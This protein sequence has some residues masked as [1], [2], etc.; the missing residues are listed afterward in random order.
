[1]NERLEDLYGQ[2]HSNERTLYE[3]R[4]NRIEREF[5]SEK[6]MLNVL[7][8]ERELN[9]LQNQIDVL[10]AMEQED[11]LQQQLRFQ[12]DHQQCQETFVQDLNVL[13]TDW[14][15]QV[16]SL[17][18]TLCK[19]IRSTDREMN[20]DAAR[21][22]HLR[23]R[24]RQSNERISRETASISIL[25]KVIRQTNKQIDRMDT[26][27][28]HLKDRLTLIK[29]CSS[30]RH[31]PSSERPLLNTLGQKR[32]DMALRRL[33]VLFDTHQ[34]TCTRKMAKAERLLRLIHQCYR[35]EQ[36]NTHTLPMRWQSNKKILPQIR[37]STQ[38][39]LETNPYLDE[40]SLFWKRMARVQMETFI[41]IHEKKC[42]TNIQTRLKEKLTRRL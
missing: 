28:D 23:E 41:L 8:C 32:T 24:I 29:Q 11:L 36:N 9:E 42:Q 34:K 21:C 18:S 5:Q 20:T 4:L 37:S 33:T 26:Q 30:I 3:S 27:R 25:K 2:I 7:F 39:R 16:H 1:M 12:R 40:F 19:V 35:L 15:S 14:K 31:I 6:Q 38:C 13:R 22:H 17:R 10:V